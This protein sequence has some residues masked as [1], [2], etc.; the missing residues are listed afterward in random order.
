[1]YPLLR[2]HAASFMAHTEASTSA[3]LPHFIT[4]KFNAFLECGI[5]ARAR[6]PAPQPGRSCRRSAVLSPHMG[7]AEGG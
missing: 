1:M 5:L 7:V 4:G 2:Q 3:E 6:A